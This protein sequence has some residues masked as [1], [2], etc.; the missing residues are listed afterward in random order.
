MNSAS[1]FG[2]SLSSN[3]ESSS[4]GPAARSRSALSRDALP[5]DAESDLRAWNWKGA[6]TEA[7]IRR[8]RAGS[9]VRF[10]T[11]LLKAARKRQEAVPKDGLGKGEPRRRTYWVVRRV[12]RSPPQ[13][14]AGS[15][16]AP[17]MPQA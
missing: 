3:C 9:N 5:E 13:E 8:R 2:L 16:L 1:L 6:A 4:T 11:R 10:D 12:P 14:N 7:S 17:R 15:C